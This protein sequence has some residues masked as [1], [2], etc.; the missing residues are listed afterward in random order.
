MKELEI[1][2]ACRPDLAGLYMRA[3]QTL[4]SGELNAGSDEGD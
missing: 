1:E 3:V 4:R 2:A